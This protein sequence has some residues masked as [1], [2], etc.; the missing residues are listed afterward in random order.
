MEGSWVGWKRN[1]E[2]LR[3]Q[4]WRWERKCVGTRKISEGKRRKGSEWRSEEIRSIL[5]SC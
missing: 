3:R 1:G 2:G 5:S 4:S